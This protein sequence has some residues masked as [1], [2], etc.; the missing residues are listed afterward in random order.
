[1]LLAWVCNA[2][3]DSF[4]S[5]FW[6]GDV[7]GSQAKEYF[8]YTIIGMETLGDD[9]R[10]TRLVGKN[11]GYSFLTWTVIYLC[12]AFGLKW[13]GRITYITMG[14]PIVLLFVF[15]GRAV[16]LEGSELGINEYIKDANWEVL[17]ETPEVWAKAVSQI[18]FSLSVTFGI[19]TAYGSH[20]KPGEPAFV[21]SCVVAISNCLFSFI[22]G[23]AVFATLGYLATQEGVSTVAKLEF[24]SFGLVFGSWPVALGTLPGGEHWI[25]LLF[26]MLFLLGIDSAFSFME[27]FLTV[28][29]DTKLLHNVDRKILSL[30]TAM[31][32]FLLSIMYATDAG[33]IFL[34][35]IDYYINFVMLLVGGFEC[36]AAGWV[37]NIEAQIERT[38]LAIVSTYFT[39]TFGSV[40]LACCL[41]FGLSNTAD[42]VWAGFVGLVGAYCIGMAT[43]H[44]LMMKEKQASPEK[45]L[46]S[47]YYDLVFRNVMELREDLSKSV[48]YMP[49][50]WALLI[51]HFIPPVIII[52]FSLDADAE[53]A[54]GEKK[55]GHYEGYVNQPYQVLGLLI[56]VFAGFLFVSSL[57]F[58]QMYAM[59]QKPEEE[60]E[61][62]VKG[63]QEVEVAEG[64][65]EKKDAEVGVEE[66]K[67][68]EAAAPEGE[69]IVA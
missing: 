37:Y 32:A 25:R 19:M 20:C 38:S 50:V 34:D 33:L 12:V 43:V 66:A 22:A 18:F 53:N 35:I 52:L 13:T 40:I 17:T 39:T 69:E 59:F 28:A 29:H 8:Y 15:L 44:F 1:M 56:V 30:G 63:D 58:P 57:V 5:N 68:E 60:E 41:W 51:K 64:E 23:F 3:F 54:L 62:V 10:P 6:A 67:P 16:S 42:A 65:M 7:T 46:G 4:G 36:F 49:T 55:F 9:L 47:M 31:L 24:A 11:V 21:N 61:A 45:T 27:G 2:F 48:G 14:L 26:V